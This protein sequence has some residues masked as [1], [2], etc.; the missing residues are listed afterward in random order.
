MNAALRTHSDGKALHEGTEAGFATCSYGKTLFGRSVEPPPKEGDMRKTIVAA[1]VA[2][3]LSAGAFSTTSAN[4]M[5]LAAPAG[6]RPA[7]EGTN[8]VEP[9]RYVCY[10]V[11]RHGVWRRHC[12]WRPSYSYYYGSPSYYSY[13][14][15]YYR[16]Y[17]YYGYYGYGG[18]RPGVSLRFRF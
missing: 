13:S 5:T 6:L 1:A 4:A 14:P 12:E 18:Y 16:P 7:I 3:A 2:T 8:V 15:Y 9:T 10:R 17:P 11:R